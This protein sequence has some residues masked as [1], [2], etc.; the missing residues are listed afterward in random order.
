MNAEFVQQMNIG[1]KNAL[2]AI[3]GDKPLLFNCGIDAGTGLL[4][5]TRCGGQTTD[6]AGQHLRP[7]KL[8]LLLRQRR[9]RIADG[10]LHV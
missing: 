7:G 9:N 3:Q 6:R 2:L 5:K 8:D 10:F 4:K 1:S